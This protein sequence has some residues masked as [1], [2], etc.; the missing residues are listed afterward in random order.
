MSF[1]ADCCKAFMQKK[2]NINKN[3]QKHKGKK[4][5]L[6]WFHYR[7]SAIVMEQLFRDFNGF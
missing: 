7:G 5:Y 4:G 1:D 3:L 2:H 6:H